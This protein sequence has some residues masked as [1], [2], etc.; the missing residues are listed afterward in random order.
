MR[1]RI[2]T[3]TFLVFTPI[4][5]LLLNCSGQEESVIGLT[6]VSKWRSNK[7]TAI[8][9]TYDDGI[10]NQFT[11][12]RPI[13]N[14]LNLPATFFVL[15]GKIEGSR[16]GQFIG[17][18]KEEII[19]ET[20]QV[21]TDQHNFFERA[22][23]IG[24]TGTTEGVSIH[25]KAGSFFEAGD[26]QGAHDIIDTGFE[27]L[28]NSNLKDSDDIVF[29][30]NVQD[31][32]SW[33]DLKQYA[34]EGHEIASHSITHPRMAVL[35]DANL[36]YELKQSREDILKF[37][38][39]DYTFSVECPYG[40]ENERV[41]EQAR[42]LYPALRNRMPE[43]WLDELNRSSK[44]DPSMS[45]NEYV[46][47]QRGP[48]TDT[49]MEMMKSWVDKC[50]SRDNIWLV[51]VFHGVDDLGWEPK[52]K[53]ELEEYFNY[54]KEK[55][56]DIWVATFADVTKYLRQRKHLKIKSERQGA[57][58]VLSF[59]TDLDTDIYNIPLT[60]KTYVPKNWNNVEIHH[61]ELSKGSNPELHHDELGEYILFEINSNTDSIVISEA[62]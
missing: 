43:T 10:I 48:L 27:K 8:S 30:D 31:T 23:L 54:I 56:R 2:P 38:G 22:S 52:T 46:Q 42:L 1:K 12:A 5:L 59:D 62:S 50:L 45:D 7:K 15:T 58:I 32:T 14:K 35:D 24:F 33:N 61:K 16:P 19:K 40:T 6:E 21:K 34:F 47:W 20:A 51:L 49:S 4:F 29:H 60:L 13:M 11:I 18:S 26:V 25:S 9:I 57:D 3:F 41:M 44:E 17:R 55:E 37:L 28:R 53:K 39:K 36:L